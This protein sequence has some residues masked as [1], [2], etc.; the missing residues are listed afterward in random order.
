MFTVVDWIH[1]ESL[2]NIVRHETVNVRL[3][4]SYTHKKI[5]SQAFTLKSSS[6]VPRSRL[7]LERN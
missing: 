2:N 1:L 5:T 7:R 6:P 4:L 3:V